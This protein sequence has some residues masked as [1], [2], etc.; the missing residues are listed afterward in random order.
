MNKKIKG[1]SSLS[2][3][4]RMSFR[5]TEM[6]TYIQRFI[7]EKHLQE[8]EEDRIGQRE[9][10]PAMRLQLRP[11]TM[12]LGTLELGQPFRTVPN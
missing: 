8:V 5:L 1:I 2:Y 4:I 7:G 11:Q 9:N 3:C 12:L 10:L 6:E